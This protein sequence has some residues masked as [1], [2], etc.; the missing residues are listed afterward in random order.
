MKVRCEKC[1]SEYNIDES[2]VPPEG[3]QVKCPRCSATF[4]VAR[5]NAPATAGEL[6]DFGE[7]QIQD[8]P[9]P[10]PGQDNL[11]LDL[12]E[13]IPSM[14]PPPPI[15]AP[16]A[17][18]SLP[19][20]GKARSSSLPPTPTSSLPG[21][22]P[23]GQPQPTPGAEGE[24]F[25]FIDH[26]I[27]SEPAPS[28]DGGQT[29]YRIR[30]KSG[31]VFGPFDSNT[32]NRMLAEHQLMGNE[33]ASSDGLNYKPLGAFEEFADT[34]R[35]LMEEP[36]SA[37]A[38]PSPSSA[39]V[40]GLD[41]D[42]EGEIIAPKGLEFAEPPPE[43]KP[44]RRGK[45]IYI[46][47]GAVGLFLLVGVGLGFTRFGFF[48]VRLL[49]GG[50]A[51][52]GSGG[53]VTSEPGA[54]GPG[55]GVRANFFLDTAAG[56]RSV[57]EEMENAL[58][59]GD[60]SM[61]NLYYLG[62]SYAAMLRNYGANEVYLK[63]A[64]E[65]LTQL[66]QESSNAPETVKVR[67]ALDILANPAQAAA[68]LQPL[69]GENS[70]DKEA[71][72][73]AGW[74]HA[75]QKNWAEAARVLDRAV[76]LDPDFAKA[77]HALGEVQSLQGDFD[78]AL[79]FYQKALEK[80][81]RHI[82]S[83]LEQA[84]ILIA[85]K[86]D[87]AEGARLIDLVFGRY[88]AELAPSEQAKA[89]FLR[90]RLNLRRHDY[91]K[92]V[93]D[94]NSAAQLMPERAEYLAALGSFYLDMGE[95]AKAQGMF[96]KALSMEPQ[97]TDALIGKGRSMWQ[98]G[99]IVKAK[100]LLEE[101][102]KSAKEDPRPLF[103]LGKIAED[104]GRPEEAMSQY[105]QAA[106]LSPQFLDARV[107]MAKLQLRTGKLAEA[108]AILSEA[109]RQN[110]R[111]PLV[112]NGL[113]EVYFA[114]K[115]LRLA[116]E[117]FEQALKLDPEL[118]V[119]H[120]NMGNTFREK[121]EYA[122]ASAAYEK[123]A[124]LSPR[125]P[126]LA[127][128]HGYNLFLAKKYREALAMYEKAIL[129]NPKDDRL[130]VRAGVAAEAAGDLAAAT[131]YFQTAT[132]INA[133][134]AEA[135]YHLG[136]VFA[137]QDSREQALELLRKSAELDKNNAAVRFAIGKLLLVMDQPLDAIEELRLA[138]KLRP[139]FIDALNFLGQAL[140][141]RQQFEEAIQHFQRVAREQPANLSVLVNI[142]DAYTKQGKFA[143]ALTSYS[144][145]YAKNPG[146]PGLAYRLGRTYD[147]LGRK[148]QAVKH[149]LAAIKAEPQDPMPHYYLG[150][151]Y[152]ASNNVKGAI[153]EFRKYLQLRPDA[154]DAE[155][156]KDE[157]EYLRNE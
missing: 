47:V 13:E 87:D 126:D 124:T 110:P 58:R 150:H 23:R 37:A 3:L 83:A 155:E 34:I 99:D 138:V 136:Q 139:D 16:P 118:P 107:A 77:F 95:F 20:I 105:E 12:P 27:G 36:I 148:A 104:L 40:Q 25:D 127:Y 135:F 97:N 157:I 60:D 154:P 29:R 85:V 49:T 22:S 134:N 81:P 39:T 92:V 147:D 66:N 9:A 32:I 33:E 50:G 100:L 116:Q 128:E 65:V 43:E 62:L 113:G 54:E 109:V 129:A 35:Q 102:S 5:E 108:L 122:Q 89:H 132:G 152:K 1:R 71:L 53:G 55:V 98:N 94:L 45:L 14:A 6:F 111:S 31:K 28:E 48:G 82:S 140:A 42:E 67:A 91:E 64:R 30:R 130:Y 117:E 142:G 7:V 101:V 68:T 11:E 103:Y 120:F 114:Q 10:K 44:A 93:Q 119:A 18:S 137:R 96:E 143:Q 144:K 125:F 141:E 106:K 57:I 74:A 46:L 88:F 156:V 73:L 69:I 131:K 151:V 112:H 70:R 4:I 38:P 17:S 75:Y 115:N 59:S 146:I 52:S 121:G 145:A 61:E 84:Q 8:E 80:N 41:E 19:P 149:Y 21:V 79:L 15:A 90:S 51:R 133:Q 86:G 63:R 72:F 153:A 56:Y 24:I 76:V 26:D 78:N 2:R 123:V